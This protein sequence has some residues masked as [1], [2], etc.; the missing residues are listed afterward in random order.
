[1]GARALAER[2]DTYEQILRTFYPGA[3]LGR[4]AANTSL[5]GALALAEGRAR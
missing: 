1:M 5:G 3:E 2:G 4:L